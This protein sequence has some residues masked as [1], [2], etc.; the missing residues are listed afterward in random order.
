MVLFLERYRK[1]PDLINIWYLCIR[2]FTFEESLKNIIKEQDTL[3]LNE[4]VTSLYK[5]SFKFNR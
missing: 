3:K 4:C 2:K 1:I 5:Y